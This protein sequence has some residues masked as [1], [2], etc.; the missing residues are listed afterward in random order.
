M[1][2]VLMMSLALCEPFTANIYIYED[3]KRR[4]VEVMHIQN[5]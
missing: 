2:T 5:F 3:R 1:V 4:V